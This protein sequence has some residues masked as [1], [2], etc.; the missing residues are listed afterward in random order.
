[1]DKRVLRGLQ[2]RQLI[3]DRAMNIASVEGLESLSVRRL[4]T[5]LEMSKSG[6]FAQ[7]GSKEELQLATVRAAIDVFAARVV[8]PARKAPAGIRRVRALCEAWMHYARQPVFEGGCF[9]LAAAPEFDARPGRVRDAIASARRDWQTLYAATIAE[10]QK[11][12]EVRA[13]IDPADLAFELDALART[14]AEDAALLD[15]DPRYDRAAAIIL[16]RLA[17]VATDPAALG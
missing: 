7:F 5:E 9:F 11:L 8:R 6:V 2:S 17:S 4:A 16:A 3:L 10:A 15:D 1:M 13:D 12:G 14:A